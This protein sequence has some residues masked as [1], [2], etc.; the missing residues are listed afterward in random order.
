[1]RT[2]IEIARVVLDR[3]TE[4]NPKALATMCLHEATPEEL[5]SFFDYA[6]RQALRS[7]ANSTRQRHQPP[8][9]LAKIDGEEVK[10]A[11]KR[12]A[13][14]REAWS[15]YKRTRVSVVGEWRLL[16]TLNVAEVRW[17][18]DFRRG[19]A[20]TL[21]AKAEEFTQLAKAMEEHGVEVVADLEDRVIAGIGSAA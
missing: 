2:P 16:G 8:L 10:V 15:A 6:I 3:T 19:Q 1:M 21:S 13:A 18:A 14:Q 4:T 5:A 12:M 20:S 7:A 17:V 11:S 9:H